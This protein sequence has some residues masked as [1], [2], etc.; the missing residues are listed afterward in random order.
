[1]TGLAWCLGTVIGVAYTVCAFAWMAV[2][3]EK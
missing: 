3:G 1:M 2:A